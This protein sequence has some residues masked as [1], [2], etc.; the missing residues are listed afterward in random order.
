MLGKMR[1]LDHKRSVC[2]RQVVTGA[3]S[4]GASFLG[5]IAVIAALS[6]EFPVLGLLGWPAIV[7]L[8]VAAVFSVAAVLLIPLAYL[9]Y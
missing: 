4:S 7:F 6:I 1:Q 8:A 3:A 9:L 5:L 2:A